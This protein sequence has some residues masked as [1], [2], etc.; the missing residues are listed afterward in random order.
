[1]GQLPQRSDPILS[2]YAYRGVCRS[3]IL[4]FKSKGFRR[5]GSALVRRVLGQE[6]LSELVRQC[7]IIMPAPSS[8][9]SRWHGG[10]DLAV[11]LAD[12]LSAEYDRPVQAPP[13]SLGFRWRKQALRSRSQR[14]RVFSQRQK[15]YDASYF[16]QL[17]PAHQRSEPLQVLIVDDVVTTGHTL[18]GLADVFEAVNFK[19]YTLASA[20]RLSENVGRFGSERPIEKD[21]SC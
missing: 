11:F 9:W 18:A 14:R 17:V 2:S 3:S 16:R 10:L 1:M 13:F 20:L 19:F 7:Q 6:D 12:N 8:L 4:A 21:S 15:L 5:A